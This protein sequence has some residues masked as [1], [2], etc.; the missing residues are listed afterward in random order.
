MLEE[1]ELVSALK[2][3]RH[4]QQNTS[5]LFNYF[6]IRKIKNQ[7]INCVWSQQAEDL[8]YQQKQGYKNHIASKGLIINIHIFNYP[9]SHLC[10]PFIPASTSP[11]N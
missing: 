10:G 7:F 9:D 1:H 11:D 8:Q 3:I 2:R 6:A 4:V 5:D